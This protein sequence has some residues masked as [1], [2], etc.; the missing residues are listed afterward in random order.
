MV[1]AVSVGAASVLGLASPL[2]VRGI[3]DHAIPERNLHLL[4]LL[5]AAMVTVTILSGAIDTFETYQTT[6]V[7]QEVM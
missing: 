3:I 2:F 1:V 6:V 7:G 4:M 5:A